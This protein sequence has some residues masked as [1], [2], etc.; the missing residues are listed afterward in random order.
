ME[1]T[2]AEIRMF[3]SNF[4]PRFWFLCNGQILSIA[5]NTAFFALLG[6]TYGGN[7]Q[8]TF[9]IPDFRGRTPLGTGTGPGLPNIDLGEKSGTTS[10]TLLLNNLPAHIHPINGTAA[11][12]QGGKAERVGTSGTPVANYPSITD[13]I[14]AYSTT[15]DSNTAPLINN[16]TVSPSG[17]SQPFSNRSPYLGISIIICAFGIFPSRN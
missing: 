3:A 13:G 16:L 11:L 7:G 6:T 12:I 15:S 2:I 8:T 17:S 1:G 4:S 14:N 5:S 9:A 10:T